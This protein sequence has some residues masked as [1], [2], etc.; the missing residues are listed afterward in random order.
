MDLF[1]CYQ[2]ECW[3]QF[4]ESTKSTTLNFEEVLNSNNDYLHWGWKAPVF[5]EEGL[6]CVAQIIYS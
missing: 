4:M 3:I 5:A 6:N 1:D 2:K